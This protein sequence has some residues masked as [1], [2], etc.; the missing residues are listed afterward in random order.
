MPGATGTTTNGALTKSGTGA[1]TLNG[2][3]TYTGATAVNGGK[4]FVNGSMASP[5][6]VASGATLGGTGSLNAG[7]TI[8]LG[9]H[10]APGVAAGT[11]SFTNGLTLLSG[12]IIDFQLG[13][14]SDKVFVTGGTFSVAN[15]VTLNLSNAGSFGTGSYTLFDFSTGGTITNSFVATDFAFGTTIPGYSYGLALLGNTLVLTATAVPEPSTY[16]AFAGLAVLGLAAYRR[17]RKHAV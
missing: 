2:T 6:T 1:L 13:S 16:A 9:G 14:T 5:V 17:R 11:I 10:L 3:N 8:N 7:A 15:S 12:A 4:L